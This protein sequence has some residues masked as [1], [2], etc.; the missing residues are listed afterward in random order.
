[1]RTSLK[2][3]IGL[4]LACAWGAA[5]AQTC[6][7]GALN[8]QPVATITFP[9]VTLNTD[10]SAVAAPVSYNLY[11]GTSATSLVKV[12]ATITPGAANAIKTG[13]VAGATYYWAVTAV[14]A[15]GIEGPQSNVVCKAFPKSVPNATTLTVT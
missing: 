4:L 8:Q 9:A 14:D 5:Q 1:M 10:G 3:T 13:L 15:A 12:T 6:A 2:L 11:Q 7:T